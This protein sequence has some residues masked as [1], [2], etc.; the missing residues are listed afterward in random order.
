[1]N[2]S[3]DQQQLKSVMNPVDATIVDELP[4]PDQQCDTN[5]SAQLTPLKS[6]DWKTSLVS[7]VRFLSF[8]FFLLQIN[9]HVEKICREGDIARLRSF[10]EYS[11]QTVS[12]E[13]HAREA[14]DRLDRETGLSPLHHAARYQQLHVCLML[15]S[16]IPFE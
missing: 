3:A 16:Y 13:K 4:L 11:L 15:L 2:G 7:E 1:M 14:A 9:L 6:F 5:D 10:T 12:C 8:F